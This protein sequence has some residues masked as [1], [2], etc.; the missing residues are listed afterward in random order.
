MGRIIGIHTE[1]RHTSKQQQ[2]KK[3]GDQKQF[4]SGIVCVDFVG[5]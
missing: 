4:V 2:I 5:R 1:V 3:S